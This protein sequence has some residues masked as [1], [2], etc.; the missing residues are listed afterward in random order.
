MLNTIYRLV[1]PRKIEVEFNEIDTKADSVIV[2]PTHL[3][4]CNADQRYYQGT[5]GTGSAGEEAAD[6]ADTRRDRSGGARQQR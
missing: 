3:S 2:R 6:G 1:E 5:R 4:I